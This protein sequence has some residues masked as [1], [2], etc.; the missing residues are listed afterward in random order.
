MCLTGPLR[1]CGG[2]MQGRHVFDPTSFSSAAYRRFAMIDGYLYKTAGLVLAQID[3]SERERKIQFQNNCDRIRSICVLQSPD[4]R[5]SMREKGNYS[6]DLVET[7]TI[8]IMVS[9]LP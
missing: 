2:N 7:A 5:N 4:V 1:E 8:T 9:L 6:D 3:Y